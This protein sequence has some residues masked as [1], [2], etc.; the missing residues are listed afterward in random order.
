MLVQFPDLPGVTDDASGDAA[1]I[2]GSPEQI[3]T[4]IRA[5]GDLGISHVQLV[6]DPN[7]S[8]AIT[9]MAPVLEILDR[10]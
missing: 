1:A 2:T 9:A 6:L 5:C 8:Q 4:A 7:T 3:A 10:D